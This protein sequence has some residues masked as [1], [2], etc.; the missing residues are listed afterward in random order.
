MTSNPM[1]LDAHLWVVK[2]GKI[3]DLT[4]NTFVNAALYLDKRI[5]YLPYP[6]EK[7]DE[8]V[9]Y[10]I[11]LLKEKNKAIGRSWNEWLDI[12]EYKLQINTKILIV[13]I[14]LLFIKLAMVAKL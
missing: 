2:D 11:N 7:R 9:N 4:T 12:F 8:I 3:I 14:P 1:S 10:F 6:K 13:L 5:V